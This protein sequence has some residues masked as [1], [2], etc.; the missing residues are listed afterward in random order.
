MKI[1]NTFT[2]LNEIKAN[3]MVIRKRNLEIV[4]QYDAK[5]IVEF[6]DMD[7]IRYGEIVLKNEGDTATFNL[8]DYQIRML[9]YCSIG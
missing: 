3:T 1:L 4:G 8:E 5:S 2:P 7:G 9:T 6:T